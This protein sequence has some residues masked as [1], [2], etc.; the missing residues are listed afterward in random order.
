[1]T[2]EKWDKTRRLVAELEAML[3]EPENMPLKQLMVIR[4]YLN[5]V[6]RTYSWLSPYYKGLHL[7]IDGWRPDRDNQGYKLHGKAL[8]DHLVI[9]LVQDL[10]ARQSEGNAED[11]RAELEGLMA[12]ALLGP[13]LWIQ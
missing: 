8:Q 1:M 10:M 7:T 6:V 4:G 11:R 9:R 5:Y 3:L 12:E 13:R 2:K